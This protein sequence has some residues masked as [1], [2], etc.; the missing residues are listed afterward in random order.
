MN[1]VNTTSN[2]SIGLSG[3]SFSVKVDVVP[4]HWYLGV[5]YQSS[6]DDMDKG[7]C[8]YIKDQHTTS[9][10]YPFRY[11]REI[12]SVDMR[13]AGGTK[14]AIRLMKNLKADS[15]AKRNIRLLSSYDIASLIWHLNPD[16]L[17]L[18]ESRELRVMAHLEKELD[19]IISNESRL[20]SLKTPDNTRLIIDK[21]E[22]IEDLKILIQELKGLNKMI[23][24][25]NLS[26]PSQE[27]LSVLMETTVPIY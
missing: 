10:N 3:P 6:G 23:S 24:E 18:E 11:M 25:E 27:A 5:E 13:S 12:N 2:K 17:L 8:I 26:S 14:A 1:T 16:Q 15:D 20:F 22:K 19:I 9:K 21:K 4:A 7:V